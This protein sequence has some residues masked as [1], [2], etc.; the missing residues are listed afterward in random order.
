MCKTCHDK[1]EAE[2]RMKRLQ[3][4][5]PVKFIVYRETV[6]GLFQNEDGTFKPAKINR[7]IESLPKSRTINLNQYCDGYTRQQVKLFKKTA[8]ML[9]AA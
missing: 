8:L 7:K 4:A 3:R 1:I 5:N 9:A 2:R 6:L